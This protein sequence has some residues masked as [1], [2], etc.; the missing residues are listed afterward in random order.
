MTWARFIY[1]HVTVAFN[2][3]RNASVRNI[4]VE[5][6]EHG[7]SSIVRVPETELNTIT[8]YHAWAVRHQ[9]FGKD[10]LDAIWSFCRREY[11]F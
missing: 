5:F 10:V 9:G 3:S 2:G 7:S 1:M 8:R 4:V 11:G 6:G